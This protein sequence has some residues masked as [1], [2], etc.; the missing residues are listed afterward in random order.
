MLYHVMNLASLYIAVF[1]FDAIK[2]INE[3]WRFIN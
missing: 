1:V 3:M 2:I